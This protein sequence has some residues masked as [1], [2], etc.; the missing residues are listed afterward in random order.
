MVLSAVDKFRPEHVGLFLQLQ[1]IAVVHYDV[2][3]ER[4]AFLSRDLSSDPSPSI[5]FSEASELDE[6]VDSDLHG[7]VH[8]NDCVELQISPVFGT[9]QGHSEQN[10]AL[11]VASRRKLS[12]HLSTDGGMDNGIE[13]RESFRIRK[14]RIGHS[15]AIKSTVSID[16]LLTESVDEILKNWRSRLHD[17]PSNDV[18][19]DQMRALVNEEVSQR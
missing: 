2:V 9:K 5:G 14:H 10:H 12:L 7:A 3:T 6:A 1:E 8:D 16:N 17:F 13:V 11:G 4:S 18:R 19:V 15:L